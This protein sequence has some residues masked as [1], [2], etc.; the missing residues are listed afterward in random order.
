MASQANS[1]WL[2]RS[3]TIWRW[4]S[5]ASFTRPLPDRRPGLVA[6]LAADLAERLLLQLTDALAG[7][8]VLVADLLERELLLVVE[9]KAPAQDA[10]LHG[11]ERRQET[12]DLIGPGLLNQ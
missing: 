1:G 6:Q 2:G 9:A 4:P 7:Q 8:V 11:R 10:R 3:P 12:M 5:S